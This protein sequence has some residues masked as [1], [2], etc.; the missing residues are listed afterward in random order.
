M[1]GVVVKLIPFNEMVFIEGKP[2]CL[3]CFENP[4]PLRGPEI[5][6][7][8]FCCLLAG[9]ID[10]RSVQD[11]PRG[12]FFLIEVANAEERS[13]QGRRS[14]GVRGF[15]FCVDLLADEIDKRVLRCIGNV[16]GG[17]VARS[18][19]CTCIGCRGKALG[20]CFFTNGVSARGQQ[21]ALG[22]FSIG[23]RRKLGYAR[24][25]L[26]VHAEYGSFQ[27]IAAVVFAD[28]RIG[29][30]FD[31]FKVS[32]EVFLDSGFQVHRLIADEA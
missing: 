12:L 16:C 7:A 21:W 4:C 25:F 15:G 5:I 17:G 26:V 18:N 8:L 28:R 20:R 11:I 31:H 19:S 6:H 3:I 2:A 23:A 1:V 27:R 30:S 29:G 10:A 24:S 9:G 22:G 32:A 14:E 13:F